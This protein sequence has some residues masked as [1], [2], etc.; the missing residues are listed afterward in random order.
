M[1]Q[2]RRVEPTEDWGQL[3]LL[4]RWPGQVR[5]EL[6]RPI[7]SFGGSPAEHMLYRKASRFEA[8]GMDALFDEGS[9]RRLKLPPAVRHLIVDLEG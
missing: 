8:E 1:R 6:I 4:C 2:R 5:Y 9:A 3:E 7:V